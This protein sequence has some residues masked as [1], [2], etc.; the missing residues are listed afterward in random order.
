MT[1][2]AGDHYIVI[3]SDGHAGAQMHEYRDVPRVEVP[4]RVRRLGG[5]VREPVRRPA[6]PTRVP[7][8]G[9]R[10]A[11]AR[12]RGRRRRRRG[13][14]PQHDP[15][16]LPVGEPAGPAAGRRR[17]RAALGRAQGAQPLAGRLLRRDARA[18][19][20][21]WPRSSSTTS[22]TRWP[23]SSGPPSQGL[24]G[25]ILLPGVPP[26]SDL[27]PLLP[28][29]LRPDL[30]GV[31][32]PRDADQQPQRRR[33]TGPEPGC[34]AAWPCS[35]SSLAW[36]SHRVFWHMVIGGAFARY[37]GSGSILTE[38][39]S[40][41]VPGTLGMLDHQFRALP[42]SRHRG[43]A[44]RRRGDQDGDRA[45]EPLLAHATATR[46]RASS[47][48]CE[49]PLRHEIGVDRIMWGQDYPHIEGT[50]PYTTEALRNTLRRGRHRRGRADGRAQRRRGL[51]LRPRRAR[52]GRR[53]ASARRVDEV[54]MPLDEIPADSRSIA[55]A[56]ESV[57]PW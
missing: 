42:R 34:H 11:P 5:D 19:G 1:T 4:R 57:K 16:V 6:R 10:R 25:G 52:A 51:R 12:A 39:S 31:P 38:Q 53:S 2:L 44:L 18:V 15:A 37:P 50:Y 8:L 35:W 41:W 40:G 36:F 28:R 49:T 21:A 9:Q 47:G 46:A 54:A 14:L 27:P 23:R 7:Q 43:V 22:T 32:G 24:F 26:D 56:G 48:P 33:R 30:G 17:V 13:A 55:F 20:R 3:S 45:A 29:R